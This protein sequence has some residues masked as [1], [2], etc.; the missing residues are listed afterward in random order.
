M[1]HISRAPVVDPAALLR[2]PDHWRR[3]APQLTIGEGVPPGSRCAIADA[4]LRRVREEV[5][6]EGYFRLE[7]VLPVALVGAM[8]DAVERLRAQ[9]LPPVFLFLYDEPWTM[10]ARLAALVEALLAGPYA[11]VAGFWVW[12]L[13]AQREAAGWPPHRDLGPHALYEGGAPKII[14]F[15]VPLTEATPDNGCMYMLPRHLDDARGGLAPADLQSIR[16]LPARPG[17]VLGWAHDVLHWSGRSSRR[18][19]ANR[20]SFAI[21]FQR[22]DVGE[23]LLDGPPYTEPFLD[24]GAPPS[25]A[26]RLSLVGQQILLYSTRYQMPE[27]L[28]R[29]AHG[30]V[31]DGADGAR[32]LAAIGAWLRKQSGI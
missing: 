13:D 15:W 10:G 3:L 5:V 4:D 17:T 11:Q 7:D 8:H 14:T 20:V 21:E 24:P 2:D 31:K 26:E 23:P 6:R 25:F 29:L 27:A 22:T 30:L 1:V 16:A 19:R 32:I 12:H 18:S 28:V 9:R